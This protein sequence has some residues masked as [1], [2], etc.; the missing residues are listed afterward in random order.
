MTDTLTALRADYEALGKRITE[1]EKKQEPRD[2]FVEAVDGIMSNYHT[3]KIDDDYYIVT[4]SDNI[5]T[6]VLMDEIRKAGFGVEHIDQ[7]EGH[8]EVYC[9]RSDSD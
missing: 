5:F 2:P 1:L 9:I 4:A 7:N 3:A 6:S 8:V